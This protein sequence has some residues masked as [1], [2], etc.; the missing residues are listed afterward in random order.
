MDFKKPKPNKKKNRP[1]NK[2]T[3][4]PTPKTNQKKIPTKQIISRLAPPTN[5]PQ[6]KAKPSL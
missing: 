2:Q 3:K 1:Q 4:N 6:G 5:Q